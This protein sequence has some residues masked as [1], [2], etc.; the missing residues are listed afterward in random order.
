MRQS[1][2][3]FNLFV[4]VPRAGGISQLNKPG[5]YIPDEAAA[6][7]SMIGPEFSALAERIVEEELR[8]EAAAAAGAVKAERPPIPQPPPVPRNWTQLANQLGFDTGATNISFRIKEWTRVHHI[9][10]FFDYLMHLPNEMTYKPAPPPARP[11]PKNTPRDPARPDT[12]QREPRPRPDAAD[13]RSADDDYSHPAKRTRFDETPRSGSQGRLLPS[14]TQSPP[15]PL[16]VGPR[17]SADRLPP[18]RLPHEMPPKLGPGPVLEQAHRYER[19]HPPHYGQPRH[20]RGGQPDQPDEQFAGFDAKQSHQRSQ[21]HQHHQQHQHH[22]HQHQHQ[23][24]QHQQARWTPPPAWKPDS[25][26][27]SRRTMS[28][29]DPDAVPQATSSHYSHSAQRESPSSEESA[30]WALQPHVADNCDTYELRSAVRLLQAHVRR[31]ERAAAQHAQEASSLR[32]LLS[33]AAGARD[34]AL[35]ALSLFPS[36]PR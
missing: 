18:L 13:L 31:I 34:T 36:L 22:Q 23:H 14:P 10:S 27:E 9:D 19:T 6:L 26:S 3:P 21:H 24:Q 35:R 30:E 25:G 4:L 29:L 5:S 33:R 7:A 8:A 28:A 32:T 15:E 16:A 17:W 2:H 1:F 20:H 11:D 12:L